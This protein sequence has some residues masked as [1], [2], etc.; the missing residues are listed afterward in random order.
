ML[1]GEERVRFAEQVLVDAAGQDV[2]AWIASFQLLR[3]DDLTCSA[4]RSP[5]A[6]LGWAGFGARGEM[7]HEFSVMSPDGRTV[8]QDSRML[9]R[10]TRVISLAFALCILWQL[11]PVRVP[12]AVVS[13]L[14]GA[15][16]LAVR[17]LLALVELLSSFQK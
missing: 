16:A 15:L 14:L 3:L 6:H 4:D 13:P 8:G 12:C 5:C 7:S 2:E 11:L 1:L 17:L 10:S 9:V